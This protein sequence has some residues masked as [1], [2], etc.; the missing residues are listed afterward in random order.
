MNHENQEPIVGIQPIHPINHKSILPSGKLTWLLKMTIK[1]VNF[2]MK[3]GDFPVRYV[4]LPE[5]NPMNDMIKPLMESPT[6]SIPAPP[7]Q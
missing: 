6:V 5:G 1:I 3:H 2:P 4:S 7:Q